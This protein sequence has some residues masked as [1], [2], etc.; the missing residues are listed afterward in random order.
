VPDNS[1]APKLGPSNN[2]R[3]VRIPDVMLIS[4]ADH[5]ATTRAR[6]LVTCPE[7]APGAGMREG[8]ETATKGT[9]RD[10]LYGKRGR[11]RL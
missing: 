2:Y 10:N 11:I 8:G 7:W 9:G 4:F 5:R 1:F 6:D 3:P